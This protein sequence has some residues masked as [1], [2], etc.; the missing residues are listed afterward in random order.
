MALVE[1]LN[2]LLA[3]FEGKPVVVD[4]DFFYYLRVHMKQTLE[5]LRKARVCV[6][7][8][9][10]VEFDKL[11]SQI[12]GIDFDFKCLDKFI[13]TLPGSE[14]P[15]EEKEDILEVDLF[16]KVPQFKAFFDKIDIPFLHVVLKY[17]EDIIFNKKSAF[18]C[19]ARASLKRCGGQGDILAGLCS[20]LV[21]S[22]ISNGVEP[23]NGILAASWLTRSASWAAYSKIKL[24]LISSDILCEISPLV[25]LLADGEESFDFKIADLSEDPKSE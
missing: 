3:A 11:F 6:F 8:P 13:D 9:N 17:R 23:I 2:F 15:V 22:S 12:M 19:R 20:F 24:G 7:T 21:S 5:A 4:A 25:N 10:M 16:E 14:L 1:K 18:V